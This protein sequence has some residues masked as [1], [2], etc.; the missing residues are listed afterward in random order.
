MLM[1]VFA[2]VRVVVLRLAG[3]LGQA[4]AVAEHFRG[5]AADTPGIAQ[6][7]AS[8][9]TAEAELGCGRVR[10]AARS[11]MQARSALEHETDPGGWVFN[12]LLVSTLSLAMAGDVLR[13][14]DALAE[15]RPHPAHRYRD[16]EVRLG[17]RGRRRRR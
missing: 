11:A 7:M 13:A 4:R 16:P 5:L 2:H 17:G 10:T 6:H 14:R 12:S 9:L 1:F 8:V 15:L 3:W